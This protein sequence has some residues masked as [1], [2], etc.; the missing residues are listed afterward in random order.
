MSALKDRKTRFFRLGRT[1]EGD[2]TGKA[3]GFSSEK[4]KKKFMKDHPDF[5]E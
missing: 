5:K 3:G 2:I 4:E 1:K